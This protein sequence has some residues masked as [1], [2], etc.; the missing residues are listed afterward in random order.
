[1]YCRTLLYVNPDDPRT[2]VYKHERWKW[3]GVTLNFARWRSFRVLAGIIA[4][5]P[6]LGWLVFQL[7]YAVA[8]QRFSP[9]ALMA[10]LLGLEIAYFVA[11]CVYCFRGAAA[12]LRRYPGKQG[13]RP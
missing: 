11:I 13:V 4:P 9:Q 3:M 1:M 8:R 2:F 7:G 5:A 10:L 12:D 6:L